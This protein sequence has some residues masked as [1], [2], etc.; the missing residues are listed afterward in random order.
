MYK[1]LALLNGGILAIMVFLNGMLANR[2]G[3]YL[4]TFI[5]HAI[6]LLL[7]ILIALFKKNK[8]PNIKAVPLV[9]SLSG[10]LNVVTILLNNI[11]IPQIGVTLAVGVSLFGQLV[12]SGLVEH[13]GLFKMPINRFKKEKAFGLSFIALGLIVM[14]T[15]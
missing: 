6:G 4:S 8:L 5:F 7:I 12:M 1:N 15:L 3:A 10:I 2:T 9:L 11:S 13:F 14:I